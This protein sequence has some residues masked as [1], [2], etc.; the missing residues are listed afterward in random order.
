MLSNKMARNAASSGG[1]F[2][3]RSAFSVSDGRHVK[4]S[5]TATIH[6]ATCSGPGHKT[7]QELVY[8]LL[9]AQ[10]ILSYY[11]LESAA[12]TMR[13][14]PRL[15]LQRIAPLREPSARRAARQRT[16]AGWKK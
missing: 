13:A 15:K 3:Q 4:K 7:N 9:F 10:G 5:K 2:V 12:Q 1:A 6:R 14:M 8:G 11:T 16:R